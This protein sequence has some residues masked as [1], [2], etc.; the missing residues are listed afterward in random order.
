M[1][2]DDILAIREEI[3]AL[4]PARLLQRAELYVSL[5]ATDPA[6]N[7][8][9]AERNEAVVRRIRDAYDRHRKIDVKGIEFLRGFCVKE[10]TRRWGE[11]E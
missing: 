3:Y 10:Q 2:P 4:P 5:G 1:K 8:A 9:P 6:I 7:R 11:Q